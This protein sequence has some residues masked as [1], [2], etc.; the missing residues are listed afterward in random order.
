MLPVQPLF[1]DVFADAAA[2]AVV[3]AKGKASDRAEAVKAADKKKKKRSAPSDDESERTWRLTFCRF[4]IDSCC[5][6][7]L[8][9]TV[10]GCRSVIAGVW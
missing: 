4:K 5:S 7:L 3:A 2:S 6:R 8:C 10:A 9:L 1:D